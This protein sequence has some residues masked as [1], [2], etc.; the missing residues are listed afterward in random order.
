MSYEINYDS[1]YSSIQETDEEPDGSM[2]FATFSEAKK[3]LIAHLVERRDD[4][5]FA[6]NQARKL[7]KGDIS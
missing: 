4:W 3:E 5:V 6:V 1:A 7:K 2:V